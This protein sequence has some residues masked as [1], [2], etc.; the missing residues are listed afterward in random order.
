[1]GFAVAT[2]IALVVSIWARDDGN[3]VVEGIINAFII[4]VTIVVVA[5]PEGLP[6]AV[7]IALA[8]STKKIQNDNCLIRIL[9]AC[10]TMGNATNICSDKTGTLTENRMTVVEGLFGDVVYNQE[11][12]QS[13]S[14]NEGVRQFIVEHVSCNRNAYLVYKDKDGKPL[15]GNRPMIVGNKTEGALILMIKAWGFD[16]QKV[17]AEVFHEGKDKVFSFN[18]AKKRSTT[19]NFR[20]DGSVRL[21]CKGASEW[22]LKDCTHITDRNGQPIPLTEEKRLFL[23]Q[24]ILSMA[25]NALRTLVLTHK[26]F[27]RASDLPANWEENLP[28]NTNLCLDCIVGIIDPLRG[29]VKEAVRIAQQAGVTVRMVTG[30]NIATACAIARGCGILT[31]TGLAAEGPTFRKMKPS[32]VD[33]ILPRLQVLA[34]SSPDDK[35]LL[36]TRLNG[37]GIPDGKEQ[38]EEKFKTREGVSWEVDRDRLLPG[39]REEWEA[40]RPEGGQIVGVTGDGTNDAPALKAANVGLAMGITGTK[41][42]QSAADVIIQD[43]RFSSIVKAISWGR[44][45]Y[46]SIRKFLQFQL[47]VNLVALYLVFI[48]ALAG[49]DPPLNAV[50]L[51]WVNL[52]MDTMGALAL[53]TEGPTPELLERKPYKRSSSIVS[54]TMWRNLLCQSL[55]QLTLLLILLFTGAEYF[56]V[57]K[58]GTN[59]FKYS[60]ESSYAKWNIYTNQKTSSGQFACSDFNEFCK[61]ESTSCLKET[62]LFAYN[63]SSVPIVMNDFSGFESTCLLCVEN[64]YRHYTII[65]NSF[66]FCQIFNEYTARNLFDEINPFRG[67]HKNRLFLSITAITVILQLMLV[68]VGGEFIKT[69]P[70]N[71]E[72]WGFSILFGFLS[73]FVGMAMRFIPVKEDPNSFFDNSLMHPDDAPVPPELASAVV[74]GGAKSIKKEIELV[75]V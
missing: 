34:R 70:I 16:Y 52:I 19:I 3:N 62:H 57:P 11:E 50:Q 21:F 27:A 35:Y 24:H 64:D 7:T 71:G 1:L 56:D 25:E 22:V 4:G 33:A 60:V 75:K 39:Y 9:A 14:M 23:E 10:E 37:Y 67:I 65:F 44:C 26:D 69:S 2:F 68:E 45:V 13:P 29:D 66:I 38:W 59:C 6:L 74:E 46:D 20:S 55:Y 40:T 73:I 41:V 43:D 51:L 17:R 18:S 48:G 5:I 31:P 36:V 12:F 72:Q 54:R 49:F 30:D 61:G 42:A 58:N 8:Y 28:D 53:G 63:G 47:T 32:E 15:D